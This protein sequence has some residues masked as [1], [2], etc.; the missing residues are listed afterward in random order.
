M[1]NIPIITYHKISD[2]KEFGLTTVPKNQFEDQM[3]YL[4]SNGYTSICLKD[5]RAEVTLPEKPIIITFDDGYEN[6]YHNAVPVLNNCDFK[7]VI[8][9]VTDYIGRYNAWEAAPFQQ[10]FKHLTEE[11][12][13]DLKNNGY[14]IA[15]H[16]KMHKYL[17]FLDEDSLMDEIIGSKISLEALIDEE[18]ASFCYPY[19]RFSK[20]IIDMVEKAGYRHAT[21]NIRLSRRI[22]NNPLSLNRR[23]IYT[24]DSL[25]IFKSKIISPTSLNITFFAEA[26]IQKGALASIGINAFR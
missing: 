26:L 1:F 6:I 11:Q 4:K 8:F 22:N 7:A 3:A 12:I 21:A 19:G 16:G 10:K 2:Q 9:I 17:L 18:I 13:L 5:L 14:E 23:S 15:S 25:G 24:T 20:R